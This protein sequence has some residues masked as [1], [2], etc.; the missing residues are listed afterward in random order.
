MEPLD[1]PRVERRLAAILAADVSGYSRLMGAD[2]EGTLARL[3]AHRRALVDDKIAQHR[4]RIVKTTGDGML[5]EFSSVVDAIRC[6]LE[7]QQGMTVRNAGVPTENR[8]EFRVGLNLG[9]IIIDGDDIHGDGV[10]VAARLEGLA[11]P[12]GI[13]ISGAVYEGVIGKLELRC[14]DMGEQRLKNIARP[15]HVYRVLTESARAAP[16]APAVP[17]PTLVDKPSIAVLPFTVIHGGADDEA[18]ADGL[19][20][21]IITALSRVAGLL[22]A[23][24]NSTFLYK[25]K[26]VEVKRAAQELG[27]RYVLEGSVRR[28]GMRLRITAQ[29]IDSA[30]GHHVWAEKYDHDATDIFAIQDVVTETISAAVQAEIKAYEGALSER[31]SAEPSVN[32]LVNLAWRNLYKLTRSG[33]RDARSFASRAL[34]LAPDDPR[35]NQIAATVEFHE[36]WLGYS[37]DPAQLSRGLSYAEKSV[38]G[39]PRDEY[40]YWILGLLSAYLGQHDRGIGALERAIEL[41][42]NFALGH[43]TLGSIL[44]WAGEA[45]RSLRESETALRLN[46]RDPSNFFRHMGQALAH[47]AAGR[48]DEAAKWAALV[49]NQK[50]DWFL[51]HAVLIASLALAGR[52]QEAGA[53]RDAYLFAFPKARIADLSW[54]P[55]RRPADAA[56]FTEALREA[57]LPE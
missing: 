24:R 9:D 7:V 13:C 33:L 6:A 50:A 35:V 46:P 1:P 22:V 11:H 56:R 47:F 8:I 5:V 18:I 14:E 53:A 32:D 4:G 36:F 41:N 16:K 10:N 43:G 38:S 45:E 20:E 17:S 27:V 30:S 29:L 39:N 49:A 57:G 34:A 3:K 51:G 26:P 15:I 55:F 28:S 2:E 54:L 25:G 52:R 37:S 42:P 19:T 31:S 21:D 12:G 40:S 44:A 48:H 23:A